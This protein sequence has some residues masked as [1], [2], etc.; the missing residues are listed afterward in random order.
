MLTIFT[1]AKPFCKHVGI[2]QRNALQSWKALHPDIET[3]LLGDDEG[4][5]EAARKFGLRHEPFAERNER[6]TKR[7]DYLYARAQAIAKHEVLC[8]INCDIILMQDFAGAIERVRTAHR[9]LL[10]V[11]QSWDSDIRERLAFGGRDWGADVSTL[12]RA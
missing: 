6:G 11:G 5:A 12:G 10:R 3:I 4:A 7:L 8:Y 1:T 2:I 9:E